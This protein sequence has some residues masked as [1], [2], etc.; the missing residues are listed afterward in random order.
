MYSE[1]SSSVTIATA[2]QKRAL[3]QR[4]LAK[5][6]EDEVLD[7]GLSDDGDQEIDSVEYLL[8]L[9]QIRQEAHKASQVDLK[10]QFALL[11]A[12]FRGHAAAIVEETSAYIDKVEKDVENTQD[13][14]CISAQAFADA[15][16]EWNTQRNMVNEARAIDL[17]G[18]QRKEEINEVSQLVESTTTKRA[19]AHRKLLRRVKTDLEAMRQKEQIATDAKSLLR[20]YKKLLRQ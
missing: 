19:Q 11:A 3:A 10:R 5:E 9:Q 13:A 1:A 4:A 20:R 16:R 7:A 2:R 15:A 8:A 18:I 6:T 14:E 12:E 17:N